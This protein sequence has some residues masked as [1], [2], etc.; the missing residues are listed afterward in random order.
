MQSWVESCCIWPD[1]IILLYWSKPLEN[2]GV[3]KL[4]AFHDVRER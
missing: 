3:E 1:M 4:L 2:G